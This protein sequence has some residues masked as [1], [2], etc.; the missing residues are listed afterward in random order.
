LYVEALREY[1]KTQCQLEGNA[2]L[3]ARQYGKLK[4]DVEYPAGFK[5]F[6][7]GDLVQCT[8]PSLGSTAKDLRIIEIQYGTET[9]IFT[10]TEDIGSI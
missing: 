8:I 1:V 7:L 3:T 6:G 4:I 9:D 5:S 2:F 10:L